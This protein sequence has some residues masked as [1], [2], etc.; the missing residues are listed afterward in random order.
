MLQTLFS[1]SSLQ[2]LT[3]ASL[4]YLGVIWLTML[5]WVILDSI[6]RS[7]SFFFQLFSALLILLFNILG[8]VIYMVIR[9][10]MTLQEEY[11]EALEREYMLKQT[12]G[13]RCPKCKSIVK[14]DYRMCPICTNVLKVS[15][16]SCKELIHPSYRVC[17][18]CT[19]TQ[20]D[21][22]AEKSEVRGESR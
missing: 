2:I 16:K 14:H 13:D 4:I 8:L 1:E 3:T 12:L 17:P 15:C 11:D 5:V 21:K 6:K 20:I 18:Y 10:G 19:V 9:P 22:E 7:Q